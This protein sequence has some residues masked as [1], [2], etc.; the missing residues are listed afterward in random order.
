MTD[1]V[2]RDAAARDLAPPDTPQTTDLGGSICP[3]HMI[4]ID[5]QFCIDRYEASRADATAVS[6]GTSTA[7]PLC[8]AGVLPWFSMSLTLSD[9]SAACAQAGKRICT[10][11]EWKK[12]CAGPKRTVYS[13]G[14]TY[15]P[16]TCNGIDSFCH[17][18]VGSACENIT[19]C[20]YPHCFNQPP[21][22]DPTGQACGSLPHA[23]PTATHPGCVN[24]W[25]I[26]DMNGNVW[27]VVDG[28]DGHDHFRGGAYNCIDSETLHRCDFDIT[29]GV[30]ARGFRCCAT[31]K[32][33]SLD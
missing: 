14:D 11:K 4:L 1:S 8:Q 15:T 6:Q 30:S 12:A 10:T 32:S 24:A 19:P 25:G 22:G 29:A 33:V 28:G 13:Y 17:C 7:P 5:G 23:V 18:G 21:P 31:P 2:P 9:A 20:P 3:S 26:Y 27:E 16:T